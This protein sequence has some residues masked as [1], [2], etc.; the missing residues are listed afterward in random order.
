MP[1]GLEETTKLESETVILQEAV[2]E[3]KANVGVMIDLRKEVSA[4]KEAIAELLSAVEKSYDLCTDT[5]EIVHMAE[6]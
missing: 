6:M 5:K 2:R 3:D 1:R 4:V